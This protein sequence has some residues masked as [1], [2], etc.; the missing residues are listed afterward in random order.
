[1]QNKVLLD[2]VNH[3]LTANVEQKLT[4]YGRV[5]FIETLPT[6]ADLAFYDA[7]N[8]VLGSAK[9]VRQGF[10]IKFPE[11]VQVSCIGIKST[12][13]QQIRVAIAQSDIDFNQISGSIEANTKQSNFVGDLSK[14]TLNSTSETQIIVAST[15]YK[16]LIF[17]ADKE[18]LGSI[19]IGGSDVS[20]ENAAIILEPG[21]SYIETIACASNFYAIADSD[22]DKIRIGFGASM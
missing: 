1:M 12:S 4:F 21:D 3:E 8:Q 5:L 11:S 6:T 13:T 7:Y 9:G 22:G 14:Q 17:T 2:I 20:K 18:N 19:Y 10:S 15:V 16:R